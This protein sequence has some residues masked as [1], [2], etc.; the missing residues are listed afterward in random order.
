MRKGSSGVTL[1]ILRFNLFFFFQ[2]LAYLSSR[3][4]QKSVL[5]ER[6]YCNHNRSDTLF[7][8]YS[9]SISC[10]SYFSSHQ[11]VYFNKAAIYALPVGDSSSCVRNG[12]LWQTFETAMMQPL[13]VDKSL[14]CC[15]V[16]ASCP[17]HAIVHKDH[18]LRAC[19]PQTRSKPIREKWLTLFQESNPTNWFR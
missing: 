6:Q 5:R 16:K 1:L 18:I 17:R 4:F 9:C 19:A 8:Q 3:L 13:R 7:P 12:M 2:E 15:P 14:H 10:T 11:F